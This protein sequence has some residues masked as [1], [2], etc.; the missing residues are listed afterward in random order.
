VNWV[1]DMRL[2]W[3][4]L[5]SFG[6]L[7]VLM[8]AIGGVGIWCVRL[9]T[10]D[11]HA[12]A[13]QEM[14][15]VVAV[16]DARDAIR[17]IQ[18]DVRQALLVEGAE[19]ERAARAS[20]VASQQRIAS[21]LADLERLLYLPA[22]QAKLATLKKAYADSSVQVQKIVDL[23]SKGD[24]D[25]AK[26]AIFDPETVKHLAAVDAAI[27]DL[28]E[29]KKARAATVV[30]TAQES[31]RFAMS[32]IAATLVTAAVVGLTIALLLAR[33][34]VRWVTAIQRTS[35]SLADNCATWLADALRA[36][37]DGDLSVK[38]TPVTPLIEG[39]GKDELGQLAATTNALRNKIV[40]CM[41][42]YEEGRGGLQQIVTDV[43][44]AA[45][46][47]ADTS[48][49][50]GAASGQTSA[51]VQQV[52]QAIQNVASGA[53]ETSRSAQTS[54]EA[55]DQLARVVD[56]VARGAQEQ[57]RQI[58]FASETTSQMAV[59]IDQVAG[60]AQAVADASQQ[61]K[62]SA[63]H[64]ARAVR[65]TVDGMQEI[66]AVVSEAAGKVEELGRLGEKIGAVVETINDIAEQT[67]LL[68]LNAAIEAARAGEHGRG[69]AVVADEVRKLAE[70][71]Q[72]ETR[73]ISELI[74][75]VQ[76]GT[77]DAVAAM[78]VG[79]AK[80]EQGSVR[81][82]QAGASLGEILRAVEATVGQVSG[83][84]TSAQEMAIGAQAVVDT[85]SSISAVVEESSA[86]T[87]EMAAQAGQ[88]T[89]AI[90]SIAAVSEENSAATEEVSA[91][92]EEMSAQ[93]EEM[94]AQAEE[95]AATA[96]Q[97]KTLVARFRLEG[98]QSVA[99]TMAARR[100][101][102]VGGGTRSTGV[103]LRAV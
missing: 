86:A 72:R 32:A 22:G 46:T 50:L 30:N 96:D 24:R 27:D 69:F 67:N 56:S 55:V 4:L 101:I 9:L 3:K 75:E 58:Q 14:T 8:A 95:L 92:A 48:Q 66:K 13:D 62:A 44:A 71:S 70:R 81:A 87:E 36:V 100:R 89:G 10:D 20:I 85:M 78:E 103:T 21:D 49:Q 19:P 42:A 41:H 84:A 91:S 79:S 37:A 99:E 40:A 35:T 93:V 7:L 88:V 76:S 90:Q 28:A 59:R 61:S 98:S 68:A 29:F 12:I 5:G 26:A 47:V 2:R 45:G 6:V 63:E 54:S 73:E 34:I 25:G 64:G 43:R 33:Q 51:V 39:Y 97:L 31:A 74:R 16:M 52:T 1:S 82:D 53:Q 102:D 60:N 57:A 38:V 80:V 65:E 18:R 83:I 23:E 17:T 11:I 94:G 15:A 77:K